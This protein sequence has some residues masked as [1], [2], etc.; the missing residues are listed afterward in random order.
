MSG[1]GVK[2]NRG[3][4]H[5][6]DVRLCTGVSGHVIRDRRGVVRL[7]L[8]E[9][10]L[11]GIVGSVI[12]V[13]LARAVRDLLRTLTPTLPMPVVVD[14]RL[15]W[16]VV[17]FAIVLSVIAGVACGLIPALEATGPN[18]EVA[19]RGA[20]A[21]ARASTVERPAARSP[22][23]YRNGRCA[24]RPYSNRKPDPGSPSCVGGSAHGAEN[25][26][27]FTAIAPERRGVV[28]AAPVPGSSLR[29][30]RCGT[31]LLFRG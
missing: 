21:T 2:Q 20:C 19:C 7:L 14:F 24:A 11:V 27:A 1:R 17:A 5:E 10:T 3:P 31:V 9:S 4:N 23:L 22:I 25:G 18:L 8:V 6:Y 30:D 16:R 13:V 26:I 12:G 15:D 28:A 29:T